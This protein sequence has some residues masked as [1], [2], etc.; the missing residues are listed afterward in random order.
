MTKREKIGI[1][2]ILL[3]ISLLLVSNIKYNE[4]RKEENISIESYFNKSY[5]EEKRK[6]KET[7][8][9]IL[10]IPKIHLQKGFFK[11]SS[12]NNTIKE[13]LE[14]ISKN[15]LPLENCNFILASHSGSSMIS[16][17]QKLYLLK[18]NDSAFL[19]YQKEKKEF[20][21]RNIIHEEKTGKIHLST[22]KTP[23][24]ILTTC[25]NENK[26]MQDIYIFEKKE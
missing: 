3:G 22:T 20:I 16:Y 13:G 24:L 19:Y 2:C 15:C 18:I 5:K 8:I 1:I 4:Q 9:G 17:F 7:Y 21:L 26:K 25:N 12:Q 23:R 11:F 6:D 14:V 10:E